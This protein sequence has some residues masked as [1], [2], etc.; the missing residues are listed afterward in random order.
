M[1]RVKKGGITWRSGLAADT[2]AGAK[3]AHTSMWLLHRKVAAR[4]VLQV[5]A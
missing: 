5:V 3:R 4:V 1:L 2:L